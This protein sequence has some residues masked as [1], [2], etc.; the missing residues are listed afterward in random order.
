MKY[1]KYLL[2]SIFVFFFGSI[3]TYADEIDVSSKNIILY[4]M[5]DDSILYEK[6]P[7]DQ[8][9]IASLT[10][11][12]T[13]IVA[14][15]NIDD[16]DQKVL[17]TSS[18]IDNLANDLSKAGFSQGEVVTYRDLLHGILLKSGADATDIT[19]I[20]ISGSVDEFVKLMNEK[21]K[22]LGM[23]NSN[24]ENTIGIEGNNH[25]SSARDVALLLKY[26]IKNETFLKI[27]ST[28]EYTSTNDKH[29]M[30]GPINYITDPEKMNMQYVKGAKTGYTSKAG[31]CLASIATYND[32]NYLLVTIGA[33]YDNKVQHFEDSKKI[34]EYFFDNY[35]YKKIISKGDNIVKL[36]TVYGKEYQIKSDETYKSYLNK[37]ITKDD[38]TYEYKG[39]STLNKNVKKN[40]KIGNYYI[41]Y[42]DKI[43][44]T[45]SIVSPVTVKFDLLFF[46]KQNIALVSLF[47]L[48][49]I[50][51]VA[52]IVIK[53]R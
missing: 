34:Y 42:K 12:M 25:Y 31:L 5:N 17:I 53:K 4:N 30:S 6:N 24:F 28:K 10:K 47:C 29:K 48:V 36:K 33:D 23:K 7:D 52:T 51:F 40:D 45:K 18:M 1:L 43:L 3:I 46:V 22:S 35:G 32:V 16:L 44:Y 38:L 37:N 11:I 2:I 26:A 41:K 39:K 49:I 27:F 50:L 14:I 21:A 9:Y 15:E 13:A 19:A 8:V 20:S